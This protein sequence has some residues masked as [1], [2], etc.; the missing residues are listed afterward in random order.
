MAECNR[1]PNSDKA[2]FIQFRSF[3]ELRRVLASKCYGTQTY[4]NETAWQKA[5]FRKVADAQGIIENKEF[6]ENINLKDPQHVE[7]F[8]S[9]IKNRG[10]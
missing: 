2:K 4:L 7:K 1:D 8:K 9:I 5:Y 6:A 3:D 10:N